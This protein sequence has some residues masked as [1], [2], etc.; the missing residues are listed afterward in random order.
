MRARPLAL[1][2]IAPI[3]ILCSLANTTPSAAGV[4]PSAEKN[5]ETQT[6]LGSYLAGR[7]ARAQNDTPAAA[8]YY[9]KALQQDPD[10]EVLIEYAFQMEASEGN[11]P[12]VEAL[13]RKLVEA[14]PSHRTARAFLGLVAFKAGRYQEAEEHFSE[15]SSHPI[16]ELT[17]TLA[18]AW[19][20]QAQNR[21]QDALNLLEGQK[22]PDWA[23]YFMRYHR[24][25]VADVAG[26]TA[27]ARAAYDRIA[28]G[29]QRTLRVA[30]AFARHAAHAGDTKLAQTILNSHLQRAKGEGH[31]DAHALLEQ[32]EAGKHPELLVRTPAEGLSEVFFG[33]GEALSG[34]GSLAVGVVLLQFSLYLNP[35][36]TFPLVTL[37]SAQETTKRYA[38]AI[39]SYDR[40]PKGTPL[41][42]NI[43]IRKALNLNQLER[44]DEAK[45][46]LDELAR[47]HPRDIRVF[48][49]LGSLMRGHKRYDEAADYYTQAIALIDHP[50]EKH[51]TFYYSRGTCYERLKKLPLAEADLQK[52]LQLSPNQ[53]LTLNYLGYTWIDHSRNLQ[54][55]LALI[56]K[57]VSLK[58]DDGYIVDSLGWAFYR[59]GNYKDAVKHLERAVELRP[60]D[61]TLNDHLGDAYWRVKRER[62]ARFQ[63]EQALTLQPEPADAEKIK[64][65]LEHGLPSAAQVRQ[66]RRNKQ[67]QRHDRGGKKRTE[68][69]PKQPFFQ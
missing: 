7:V 10:N 31:P 47:Q 38:A 68:V 6:L 17:S 32:V 50:E 44:V 4:G 69:N 54:Q 58:P 9:G 24:A 34:E 63:W 14:Q 3:L 21:T 66:P 37:A 67:V 8:S 11:W 30:L 27:E 59:L 5:D 1:F 12:R 35:D 56:K 46:L 55:G 64:H 15:A 61:S 36:A 43:E 39:A 18:R 42:V 51:W 19:I 53:S 41:E 13:A 16:G 52:A 60:E 45:T 2:K 33:L 65:K 23:Q 20:Y 22:L 29:D 48:E 49:A 40:I 26:R 28:K 62:E 25:L 57:A